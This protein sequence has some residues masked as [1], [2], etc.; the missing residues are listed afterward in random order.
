[1]SIEFA[2]QNLLKNNNKRLTLKHGISDNYLLAG[3]NTKV[4]RKVLKQA[5]CNE[6]N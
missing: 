5:Y 4:K 6:K 1:V 2:E 3:F